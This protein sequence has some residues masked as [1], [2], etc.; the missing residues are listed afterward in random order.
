MLISRKGSLI[1]M[2]RSAYSWDTLMELKGSDCAC[3]GPGR[4]KII[5]SRDVTFDEKVMCKDMH[6]EADNSGTVTNQGFEEEVEQ[7]PGNS[8]AGRAENKATDQQQQQEVETNEFQGY[9]LA[10]DRWKREVKPPARYWHAD[11][12]SFALAATVELEE[13]VPLNFRQAIESNEAQKWI[14]AIVEEIHS[15]IKNNIW[16]LVPKHAIQRVVGCKWIF[17]KKEGIPVVEKSR[18]KARPVA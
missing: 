12:I 13:S 18:F 1:P 17:K 4:P 2:P 14:E 8:Q 16:I 10:K 6:K 7:L 15:L 3:L 5:L 11:F 9:N